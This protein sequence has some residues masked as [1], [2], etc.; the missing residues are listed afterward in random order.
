MW[1]GR[2]HLREE[3]VGKRVVEIQVTDK[4]CVPDEGQLSFR[5]LETLELDG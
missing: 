1:C 2:G 3:N 5:T 4:V